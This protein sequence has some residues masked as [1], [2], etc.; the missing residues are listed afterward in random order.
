MGNE[1]CFS[2]T[3]DNIFKN[4]DDNT[5]LK[6]TEDREFRDRR[7]KQEAAKTIDKTQMKPYFRKPYF[8]GWS[9]NV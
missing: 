2:H 3:A 6:C 8:D 4:T 5:W 9:G 1:C 7:L